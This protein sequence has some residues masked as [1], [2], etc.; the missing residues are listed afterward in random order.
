MP[1]ATN[2]RV[3][4][5]VVPLAASRYPIAMTPFWFLLL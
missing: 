2:G 1:E 4:D 5:R 3:Q